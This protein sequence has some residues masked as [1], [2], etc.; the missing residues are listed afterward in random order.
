MTGLDYWLALC[1]AATDTP[2]DVAE[3]LQA[4]YLREREQPAQGDLLEGRR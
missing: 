3:Q 2:P 4:D 1:V